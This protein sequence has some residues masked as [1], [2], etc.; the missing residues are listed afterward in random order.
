MSLNARNTDPHTSHLAAGEDHDKR[1]DRV[2][3]WTL[4]MQCDPLPMAD[5]MMEQRLGGAN[6]GKW[7]KRRSD[8]S[9]DGML[10]GVGTVI[11][12]ATGKN[13]ILWAVTR[14]QTTADAVKPAQPDLFA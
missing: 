5:F 14:T 13:Q 11:N 3:V 9:R 12:P 4:F 7:R 6:N 10:S 2:T 1:R 8:L